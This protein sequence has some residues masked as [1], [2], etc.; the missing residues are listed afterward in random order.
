LLFNSKLKELFDYNVINKRLYFKLRSSTA[1]PAK[2][3][4]LPKLHKQDIPMRPI[5]AFC[6]SPT[7]EL[8]K[9]LAKILHPL[10]NKS[11]H[12]LINTK[13]FVDKIIQDDIPQEYHLVSFDVKSLFTSV[14]IDLAIEVTTDALCN[15]DTLSERTPLDPC[16]IVELLELCL[17]STTFLFNGKYYK[18][19]H[20]TP[21]GSPISVIVAELAMQ[22]L[23]QSAL[24]SYPNPPPFW[25]R[26]V[27]DSITALHPSE[28]TQFLDHLN[29]LNPHIQFTFETETNNSLPFLDCLITRSDGVL[30][31]SV[32]RKPT[33]TDRLLDFSSY[34]PLS[35][36]ASTVKT[37]F[38]RAD[39]LCNTR[40]AK[41]SEHRALNRQ[42]SING[43]APSF[44]KRILNRKPLV[45]PTDPQIERPTIVSIPYVKNTSE[46]VARILR[47]FNIQVAH[48]PLK[49]LRSLLMK[50]KDQTPVDE[51]PG[52]IYNINCND[53][54][55]VYVGETGR[56]LKTRVKEDQKASYNKNYSQSEISKH[57]HTTKHE[58]NW[59]GATCLSF[60]TNYF[61]RL[62]LEGWASNNQQHQINRSTPIP[63]I[64]GNLINEYK[65]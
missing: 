16:H 57:V 22:H 63:P 38:D 60:S 45:R 58:I 11:A 61:H 37:L 65:L 32:Y 27:D 24:S 48:K 31:T 41:K 52:A 51:R 19:L 64:Y 20:G 8:S 54:N 53:C 5:L 18:Q 13:H 3:Y 30:T 40:L 35:H 21:M 42:F 9:Y 39:R 59:G 47:P 44:V 28:I 49:T 43:Y 7:Y 56:T 12:K 50:V 10:T 4:G 46:Q 15:D 17:N 25:Y 55:V 34:H 29:S 36:K 1:L 62:F 23:E 2:L 6:G 33:N 14:P 26:Y